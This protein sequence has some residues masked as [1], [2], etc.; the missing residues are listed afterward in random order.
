MRISLAQGTTK[1]NYME[2][3]ENQKL[4]FKS[5]RKIETDKGIKDLAISCVSFANAEGG[6]LWIGFEDKTKAPL[7]NQRISKEAQN[8]TIKKLKSNCYN[9]AL[10]ATDILKYENGDEYF[11]IYV[12]PS[13]KSFASTA[14]GRYYIR[15]A[16]QC[17]P[18]RSEDFQRVAYEK[19]SYLWEV[20][21]TE[22]KITDVPI[23]KITSL[24]AD[25]R[26]SDRVSNHIKQMS[27]EEILTNY[28]LVENGVLTNL[29]TLWLGSAQQRSRI[30]YP[31][32]VQYIVYDA[33]ENKVRKLDWHDNSLNPMD[34]LLEIEK[35]AIE[36]TYSFEVPNGLFRKQIRHYQPKVIRELLLNAFA[37]KSFTIS[38]DIMIGVYPD[39]LE[40]SSPGSLP[41]G[42]TKDNILHQKVR[43]NP[44]M[45][46]IMH[47]LG[48]MEGEGSGYDLIYEMNAL[49]VKHPPLLVSDYNSVTVIQYSEII[50][51]ELLP[52]FDFIN[53]NY[54]LL[55]QKNLIALGIIS[56]HEK[57]NATELVKLLQLS[58]NARLR[59]YVETLIEQGIVITRGVKKG[60]QYIINPKLIQAAKVNLP[61]TLK[62]IEPHILR[63]L[64]EEDLRKHPYSLLSE[65]SSRLPDV[66]R[67]DIQKLIYA[68]SRNDELATS[69]SKTYRRYSLKP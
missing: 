4:D 53:H 67:T 42:V 23:A 37:H 34:L 20:V 63:A 27:E 35:Q 54:P 32:T 22:F 51:K 19:Q 16:D 10:H 50:N 48:L 12:A 56:Q 58:E 43:R 65:I 6:E 59:P 3:Y 64:I 44:Y 2:L 38:G 8:E 17:V 5:V 41:L 45:I 28:N 68:M 9:V 47:D 36:L 13:L 61:T 46:R 7:P 15:V 26:T 11:I 57:I 21:K 1:Y 66:E 18:M 52:L 29:G 49:D 40:I 14:D 69:G 24:C 33:Q 55:K 39:R 62:A 31:I 25:L 60:T 30:L